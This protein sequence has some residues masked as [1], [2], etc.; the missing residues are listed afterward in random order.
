M[1]WYAIAISP[2]ATR[3]VRTVVLSR[4]PRNGL[5]KTV[6]TTH[7]KFQIERDM[8]DAGF[9]AFVPKDSLSI[10]D[11]KNGGDTLRS[12][13]MLRGY[14]FVKDPH[15]WPSLEAMRG[16][17]ALLGS[18]GI[19]IRIHDHEIASLRLAEA[20]MRIKAEQDIELRK[21]KRSAQATEYPTAV[22][23]AQNCLFEMMDAGLTVV[24]VEWFTRELDNDVRR[25]SKH[26]A[27]KPLIS[28]RKA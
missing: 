5:R 24:D 6:T 22:G 14:A 15:D 19:P 2:S 28:R 13:P 27:S 21:V 16:V 18:G 25:H 23:F 17:A 10:R 4:G 3:P 20:D 11:R 26:R 1:T 7:S 8:A 9:L 12:F